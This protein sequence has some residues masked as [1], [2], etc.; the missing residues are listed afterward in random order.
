MKIKKLLR[1]NLGVAAIEFALALPLLVFLIVGVV[2]ISRFIINNQRVDKVSSQ[3]ADVL[4]KLPLP[5]QVDVNSPTIQATFEQLLGFEPQS[6]DGFVY[7]VVTKGTEADAPNIIA[8]QSKMNGIN[9]KIGVQGDTVSDDDLGGSSLRPRDIVIIVESNITHR[10]LF[11]DLISSF[12]FNGGADS[13]IPS[14]D[15]E[16]LYKPAFSLYR[17]NAQALP[18]NGE[19]Q[20]VPSLMGVCGYYRDAEDNRPRFSQSRI[21]GDRDYDIGRFGVI[22]DAPHP[23]RCYR[24]NLTNEMRDQL[25]TCVPSALAEGCPQR[26]NCCSANPNSYT[27]QRQ[28]VC[29]GYQCYESDDSIRNVPPSN[30]GDAI[31]QPAPP[32]PCQGCAC[33]NSCPPAPPPPPPPPPPPCQGCACNNSCPPPPPA[34][35]PVLGS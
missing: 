24:D 29:T 7:S 1:N 18:I 3:M 15:G 25:R 35:P 21:F 34:Q 28:R 17:F 14:F 20:A 9:S 32:P 10:N 19:E 6:G 16:Q 5:F 8:Y 12:D 13:Q 22:A 23:C 26:N 2:E 11:G 30:P 33:T 4:S 27:N 31:C